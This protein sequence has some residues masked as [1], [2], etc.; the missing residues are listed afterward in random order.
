MKQTFK[1][2]WLLFALLALTVVTACKKDD[3]EE[4]KEVIAGFKAEADATNTLMYTFTNQSQNATSYLW[5]FGDGETSTETNPVH[6]FAAP[7]NYTVKL[8][9]TGAGGS[10]S[11]QKPLTVVNA[12]E[13]LTILTGGSEKTWRLIRDVSTGRFP[14]EVG[15]EAA[16]GTIWWAM[17]NG[18]DELANRPCMLNDDWI[19]KANGEMVFDAHG[20]YWGEGGLFAEDLA[21][22]CNSTDDMRGPNNEDLSAW[23]NGTHQWAIEDGKLTITGLGAF[24]GLQK[25]ATDSEVTAPQESVT[26]IINKL[27]EGTTDTLALETKY[28]T[29]D[30]Q[31]AHWRFVLVHYDDP[32]EEPPLPGP[33]PSVGFT[34]V[35]D[36]LTVTTTN[37]TTGDNV[38]YLWDFGDGQTSTEVSPVHTYATEGFF[39]IKLT[40]TNANGSS[41]ASK[42]ALVSNT[43]ITDALLQGGSMENT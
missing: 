24:I 36:G 17:G 15:P 34:I 35:V 39:T 18:N 42:T 7:G 16:P 4:K 29:G 9:A 38:T 33:K 25:V 27:S 6:T 13:L 11:I 31:A 2:S 19:F 5:D 37:T 28:T 41:E 26:Y 32:N 14:L 20:D 8:T 23:G 1:L 30:G 43:Q 21:N 3:D 12:N 22:K 40:A 10:N